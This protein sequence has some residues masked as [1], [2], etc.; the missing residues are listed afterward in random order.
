M[1]VGGLLERPVTPIASVG[2][3]TACLIALEFHGKRVA[4]RFWFENPQQ[5]SLGKSHVSQKLA[6]K[7]TLLYYFFEAQLDQI[8]KI[9]LAEVICMTTALREIPENLFLVASET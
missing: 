5:F 9:S 6:H 7:N 8:R 3:T 2:A 4:D 1:V